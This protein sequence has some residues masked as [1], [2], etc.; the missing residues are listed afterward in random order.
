MRKKGG[1]NL[2][3]FLPSFLPWLHFFPPKPPSGKM[4]GRSMSTRKSGGN[5]TTIAPQVKD[6]R[7]NTVH[8]LGKTILVLFFEYWK[9]CIVKNSFFCLPPSVY[10]II[11]VLR[12]EQLWK[13]GKKEKKRKE[14]G[15]C[16]QPFK[17]HSSERAGRLNLFIKNLSDVSRR[18][19][20]LW[21]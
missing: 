1:N 7:K 3:S 20:F 13:K 19:H 16:L 10:P 21:E 8:S 5:S 15:V 14:G 18:E 4:K 11:Y 12:K 17:I 9:Y 6:L 2:S